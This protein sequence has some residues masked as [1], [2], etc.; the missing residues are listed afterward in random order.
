MPAFPAQFTL[1]IGTQVWVA[2]SQ[3]VCCWLRG[4]EIGGSGRSQ[5]LV[6]ASQ[7]FVSARFNRLLFGGIQN[8]ATGDCPDAAFREKI[9][10]RMDFTR[11]QQGCRDGIKTADVKRFTNGPEN[12][13]SRSRPGASCFVDGRNPTLPHPLRTSIYDSSTVNDATTRTPT[14][15]NHSQAL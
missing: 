1:E 7:N 13:I 14:Q 5:L 10:T 15:E 12:R 2:V 3:M 6:G 8:L 9:R 11:D 4:L